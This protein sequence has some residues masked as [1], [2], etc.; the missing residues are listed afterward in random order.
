[1]RPPHR[2]PITNHQSPITDYWLLIHWLLIHLSPITHHLVIASEAKRSV[3]N[4][5]SN[6]SRKTISWH[7]NLPIGRQGRKD[8]KPKSRRGY[9]PSTPI[10][11]HR[12]PLPDC[13]LGRQGLPITD[14][15]LLIHWLLIHWL[16]IT[17][18]W[19][20]ITDSP[21]TY[22]SSLVPPLTPSNKLPKT[23]KQNLLDFHLDYP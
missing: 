18:Y 3:P 12:S 4:I 2:S 5:R 17:D 22:H 11:N 8:A 16:L 13:R 1:M 7:A 21:I 14:H 6:S 20:L 23:T 19:L 10:T 15:W 9:A